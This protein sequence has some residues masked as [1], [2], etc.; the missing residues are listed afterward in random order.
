MREAGPTTPKPGWAQVE[1][2]KAPVSVGICTDCCHS[3]LMLSSLEIQGLRDSEGP[4]TPNS[5]SISPEPGVPQLQ[6]ARVCVL[7]LG[8][9]RN[10]VFSECSGAM[11]EALESDGLGWNLTAL[12][13][14]P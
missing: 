8:V 10:P 12:S 14:Q 6:T 3:D 2:G 4:R 11:M 5:K 9:C 7:L 1:P 13:S